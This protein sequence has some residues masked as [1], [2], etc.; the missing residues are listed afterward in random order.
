MPIVYRTWINKAT[1]EKLFCC[2]RNFNEIVK[3]L[4]PPK[5]GLD[6]RNLTKSGFSVYLKMDISIFLQI[7]L[8]VIGAFLSVILT[9]FL[10]QNGKYIRQ[11]GEAIRQNGEAIRQNGEAIRQNGEALRQLAE[12]IKQNNEAIKQNGE[13]LRYLIKLVD[14]RTREILK[15]L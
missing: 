8:T 2:I 13:A 15:R 1:V 5:A 7:A 14:E 6:S 3:F 12:I 11:N 4:T 10:I 9:K